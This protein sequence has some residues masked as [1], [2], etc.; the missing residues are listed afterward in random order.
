[1]RIVKQYIATLALSMLSLAATAQTTTATCEY[2][3]DGQFDKRQSVVL[4]DSLETVLDLSEYA[5]GVHTLG[6][7]VSD[8]KGR[9]GSPIVKFFMRKTE[10]THDR[11]LT[12]YEYWIDDYC[13]RVTGKFDG[14]TLSLDINLLTLT[15][16]VHTFSLRTQDSDGCWS[17]TVTKFFLNPLDLLAESTVSGYRYWIDNDFENAVTEKCADGFADLELDLSTLCKGAHTITIQAEDSRGVYGS[18]I[19]KFFVVAEPSLADNA[20]VAYEYWFNSGKRKRVDVDPANPLVLSDVWIDIVDVIPNSVPADY[21]FDVVQNTVWCDD[22]V[23]FGFQTFDA[24]GKGSVAV[25]SDTFAM[26]VPVKMEYSTLINNVSEQFDAPKKG[27]INGFIAYA[28]DGD[29]IEWHTKGKY[30]ADF[31]SEDGTR[32]NAEKKTF[33]DTL[34]IYTLKA[35]G[36]LTYM[37]TYSNKKM[38]GKQ[39]VKFVNCSATGIYNP[40]IVGTKIYCEN[41]ALVIDSHT[42][43]AVAVYNAAGQRV[44]NEEVQEGKNI[45]NLVSGIY[46]VKTESKS[47]KVFVR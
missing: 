39:E 40:L 18:P 5:Y 35:Q 36:K 23:A 31:Y 10:E 25:L 4:A 1:M 2:W 38:T 41:G 20:I 21:R 24:L 12:K 44:V 6:L 27:C 45:F 11:Q 46:T 7:R 33:G 29:S 13:N 9:W 34:D 17:A 47:C 28:S 14:E 30:T 26:C 19:S 22:N 32:I 15:K 16:G 8:S 37:L 43:Q 42:K 3:I